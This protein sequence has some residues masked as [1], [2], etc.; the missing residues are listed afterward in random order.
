MSQKKGSPPTGIVESMSWTLGIPVLESFRVYTAT[1]F[2]IHPILPLILMTELLDFLSR[3]MIKTK[4]PSRTRSSNN[5][6]RS[7]LNRTSVLIDLYVGY[8]LLSTVHQLC[9]ENTGTRLYQL[10]FVLEG[11]KTW[12]CIC[13]TSIV[14]SR[15]SVVPRKCQEL[16]YRYATW[17]RV[18]SLGKELHIILAFVLMKTEELEPYNWPLDVLTFDI[19]SI[20]LFLYVLATPCCIASILLSVMQTLVALWS[21]LNA[22]V[23]S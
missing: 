3:M 22:A 17:I 15:S 21:L 1:M 19:T 2:L 13:S 4:T 5:H 6:S 16:G 8:V 11:I 18:V 20:L 9:T 14:T 12:C 10:M 7:L 23:L